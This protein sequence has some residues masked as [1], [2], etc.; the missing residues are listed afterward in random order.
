MT[1]SSRHQA[2]DRLLAR[3]RLTE[4]RLARLG[5]ELSVDDDLPDSELSERVEELT[6]RC[7]E[8]SDKIRSW[9]EAQIGVNT[10]VEDL[11][12][13]V[14]TLETDLL[15]AR[16]TEPAGYAEAI[17]R[18]VRAW[19][20]RIDRLRLQGGLASM[21]A[22]DELEALTNRLEDA[23]ATVL[24]DLQSVVGDAKETV[25]DLRSDV[26]QVLVDVRK[27]VEHAAAALTGD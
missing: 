9:S 5:T 27:A 14:D 22:R 17:D 20:T 13:A 21:E 19:R 18:Q 8:L 26:E 2:H 3:V 10:A 16:A 4:R 6:G 23:R 1:T 25:V 11:A 12:A 7:G 15:A 24:D